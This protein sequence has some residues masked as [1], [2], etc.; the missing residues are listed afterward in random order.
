MTDP[1]VLWM[2]YVKCLKNLEFKIIIVQNV[3][4]EIVGK[5]LIS[6]NLLKKILYVY[7]FWFERSL[8]NLLSPVSRRL[9][10]YI[11]I[12][13]AIHFQFPFIKKQQYIY[14]GQM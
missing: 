12:Y 1:L 11:Y 9:Y 8:I 13:N 3:V 14:K 6:C 4:Q 10:I 2:L 7:C 5:C